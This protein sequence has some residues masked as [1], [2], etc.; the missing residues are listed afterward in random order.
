MKK[1]T[2]FVNFY[3]GPC[4]GKST[5]AANVFAELK[6]NK[7]T[8]EL[9]SEYAKKLVFEESF[10]KMKDQIYILS[11]QH[12]KQVIV[13]GKVDVAITDSPF[14]LSVIYDSNETKYL[15]ELALHANTNFWNINIFLERGIDYDPTGRIQQTIE[16]AIIIDNKLKKFL[17]DNGIDFISIP[18]TRE[19]IPVILDLIK[20]EMNK[21]DGNTN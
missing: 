6:W 12:G 5:M 11:K 18:S 9:I 16:D 19:S 2:F 14:I 7:I 17:I 21:H 4:S 15:K 3:G 1:K 20:T 8:C 13:D 10:P